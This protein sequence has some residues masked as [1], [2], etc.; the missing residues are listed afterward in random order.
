MLLRLPRTWTFRALSESRNFKKSAADFT[1]FDPM[2][3]QKYTE[4]NQDLF[5]ISIQPE[6]ILAID[7]IAAFNQQEGLSLSEEEIA[8]LNNLAEKLGR[9]LDGF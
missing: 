3:S 5:T 1:G 9:Q 8:Y 2:L 6:A 7:D 4:L